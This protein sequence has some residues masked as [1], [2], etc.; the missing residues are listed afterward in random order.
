MKSLREGID[1]FNTAQFWSAHEAWERDWLTAAGDEKIFLQGL[2]Q[3]A[4]AF[5]HV[6]RGTLSGAGRLIDAAVAKLASVPPGFAG[7]D[8]SEAVATAL[9]RR[10]QITRGDVVSAEEFP[11]LRYNPALSKRTSRSGHR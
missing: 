10:L 9:Q 4:A 7:V 5:H 11:P 6:Q 1:L 3:L 8:R 2:I